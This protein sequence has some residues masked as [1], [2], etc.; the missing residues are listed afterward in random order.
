VLKREKSSPLEKSK[1]KVMSEEPRKNTLK[2]LSLEQSDVYSLLT[3][4]NLQF[5]EL[6]QY[7]ISNSIMEENKKR[8][9]SHSIMTKNVT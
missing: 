9:Y 6:I 5:F 3:F 7:S 8:N 1:L 4:Y 2:N